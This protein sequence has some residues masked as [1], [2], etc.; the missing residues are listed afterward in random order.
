MSTVYGLTPEG[1]IA[2]PGPVIKTELD[3]AFKGILGE[4]AGSEPDGSIPAASYAGQIVAVLT[5]GFAGMWDLDQA[6]VSSHDPAEAVDEAQ[7]AVCAIT[8]TQRDPKRASSVTATCTGIPTT[9]LLVGRVATVQ[10]TGTR[11][12]SIAQRT[13]AALASWQ[14]THGYVVGDRVTNAG[15]AYHCITAGTSAGAGG[16]TTTT[17]DITDGSVH[18]T[19]LGIG[20]G[21]VDVIFQAEA[22]GPLAAL[23]R[24][25]NA[26]ATPASGWQGVIN[27]ADAVVG[28]LLESNAALRVRREQELAAEGTGPADAIRGRI[29]RVNEG[30]T[31]PLHLPILA[32][33]VFFND[34]DVVDG[35]G[36][37]PHSVEVL[38][39]YEGLAS[40]TTDQDIADEVWRSVAAGIATNGN[41]TS[42]VTDSQGNTQTVYWSK[43][44]E[45]DLY[46]KA[47][48]YYDPSKW[49]ASG[50]GPLVQQAATSAILT[51]GATY[52]V[53]ESV[54]AAPLIAACIDGPSL[55]LEGVAVAP[56]PPGSVPAPGI[57]DVSPMYIGTAP[58]PATSTPVAIGV[59]EI[60]RF[61][62]SRIAIT[63]TPESP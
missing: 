13:I 30:S 34:G 38:A 49:P 32:C 48:V 8:G 21:A 43:P 44:T 12:D 42:T 51:L 28:A 17:A 23:A 22:V 63:A 11:F 55:V 33:S 14:A 52:P 1:F 57:L 29:L 10:G 62:A 45:I 50:A 9:V 60:A 37:P 27:L 3:T 15:R 56:A 41:Q 61:A 20:T 24:Q 5:D 18:W 16:P 39:L 4:S 31:D 46:V 25:L 6:V 19:F 36:L 26:I 7:D 54:R 35:D 58:N 59:R 47:T 2:K 53:G 40:A